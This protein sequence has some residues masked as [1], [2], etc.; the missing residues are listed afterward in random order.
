MVKRYD[1]SFCLVFSLILHSLFVLTLWGWMP[2][3]AD[4]RP[5]GDVI[6]VSIVQ[7]PPMRA[8]AAQASV[9]QLKAVSIANPLPL[10]K[11]LTQEKKVLEPI[12]EEEQPPTDTQAGRDA[13]AGAPGGM[14]SGMPG[15]GDEIEGAMQQ[16]PQPFLH[17]VF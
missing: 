8:M 10:E 15:M 2:S 5:S 16:A 1:F 17:S 12:Q 14:A 4:T 9:S 3:F 7:A 11:I 6:M 13:P